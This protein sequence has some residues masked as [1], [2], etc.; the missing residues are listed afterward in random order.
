MELGDLDWRAG[1]LT[2][3]GKGLVHDRM[4]LPRDVGEAVAA[5]LRDRPS[6]LTRRVFLRMKAPHRGFNHPSTV[7]TIVRRALARAHVT[8]PRKGAHLLRHSLAT[9]LLR[10]GASLTEIGEVLRHRSPN[11]TEI[12]TK[13]DLDGLRMLA[14]PWPTVGGVR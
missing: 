3:R 7:S 4:P 12:Y 5:Y 6:C 10:H 2:V 1:E 14:R 13:V 9:N 8:S 11:T